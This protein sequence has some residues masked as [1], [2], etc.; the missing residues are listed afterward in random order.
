[1]VWGCSSGAGLGPL[2]PV[3]ETLNAKAYQEML[4]NSMLTAL[5]EQFGDGPSCSNMTVHQ[6]TKQVHKDM[7]REFGVDELDWWA[8]SPDLILME[9]LC[10]ELECRLRARPSCPTSVCDLTNELLEEW[11]KIPINTEDRRRVEAVVAAKGPT[12]Y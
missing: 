10:D 5:W 11:S 12:S 2:V 6:C 8:H 4:D 1:M 7:R 9:H 3:R